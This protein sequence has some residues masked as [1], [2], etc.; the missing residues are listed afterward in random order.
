MNRGWKGLIVAAIAGIILLLQPTVFAES[1]PQAIVNQFYQWW[2]FTDHTEQQFAQQKQVFDPELYQQLIQ[3]FA[4]K[5]GQD[6]D[7][8]DFDPFSGT[9]VMFAKVGVRS[10]QQPWKDHSAEVDMDLYEGRIRNGK[11]VQ[12]SDKPVS[13]KVLVEKQEQSWRIRNLVYMRGDWG[14][15]RCILKEINQPARK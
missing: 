14:N 12:V 1:P 15:L 6:S 8:L 5:P 13:V 3:A 4:K 2:Y 10:V 9:Q 11:R 7:F